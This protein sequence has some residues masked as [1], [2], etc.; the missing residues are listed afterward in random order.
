[1]RGTNAAVVGILGAA[2]YDPVWVGA[3][4]GRADF[5]L[6]AAGFVLLLAGRAPPLLVVVATALASLFL[7]VAAG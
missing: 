1:M 7:A 5:A 4:H 2:L 6:A 3:V